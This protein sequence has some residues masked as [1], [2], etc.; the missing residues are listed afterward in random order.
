MTMRNHRNAGSNLVLV[1]LL[2]NAL[3]GFTFLFLVVLMLINP[4]T[5]AENIEPKSEYFIILEWDAHS[6]DD[7]D[8]WVKSPNGNL[9]S[10]RHPQVGLLSLDRDDLGSSS[11][12][13]QNPY[14]GKRTYIQINREVVSIRGTVPGTYEINAHY[15]GK[16]SSS[17]SEL[18]G[19]V[20]L[21]KVNP[22]SVLKIVPIKFI[23]EGNVY[24]VMRFVINTNGNV[25]NIDNSASNIVLNEVAKEVLD[26]DE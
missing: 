5:N 17:Q 19:T 7:V 21:V 1:D 11:D 2:F 24:P 12:V 3:M 15:Y 18:H 9:V 14:T 25:K 23:R 10:F 8:L 4:P 20:A 16:H 22:Y 26:N 13:A 6:A